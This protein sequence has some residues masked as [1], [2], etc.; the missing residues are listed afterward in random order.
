MESTAEFERPFGNLVAVQWFA[1]AAMRLLG[2]HAQRACVHTGALLGELLQC[3]V[4]LPRVGR[5]EMGDDSLG[6]DAARRQ[7]D[8]DVPLG[9]PHRL[10]RAASS[11][12]L[13][14][15]RSLLSSSGLTTRAHGRT[16]PR[17]VPPERPDFDRPELRNRMP[18]G[19]LDGLLEAP[20]LD[21]VEPADRLLRLGER[22]VRH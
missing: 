12:P 11:R 15:A 14:T 8:R 9:L 2:K 4:R 6:L 13:G 16:V 21:D 5:P 18:G 20:A 22:A 17:S 7:L 3:R 1:Q 19:D 10:R